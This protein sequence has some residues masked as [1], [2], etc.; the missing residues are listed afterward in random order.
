MDGPQD[1]NIKNS[2]S[3]DR[4]TIEDSDILSGTNAQDDD[5][6]PDDD[7]PLEDE[8]ND[9]FEDIYSELDTQIPSQ[10]VLEVRSEKSKNNKIDDYNKDI[11][12]KYLEGEDY[13]LRGQKPVS[14]IIAIA[15]VLQ[16]IAF[17]VLIYIITLGTYD[18][19]KLQLLLD[20]IKFYT[21]AVIVEM[22]GLCSVVVKGVFSMSLGKM[23]E[24][25]IKRK[26]K[27]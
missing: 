16:L 17:N 26:N 10:Q 14:I 18:S 13:H 2:I 25:I 27:F 1:Q 12:K 8:Y 23:V 4:E 24:H 15:V 20:F 11:I 7:Y 22:L 6:F 3:D 5:Y 21:G 9:I 19:Y